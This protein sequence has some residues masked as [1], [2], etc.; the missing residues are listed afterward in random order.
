L[1]KHASSGITETAP[2]SRLP[3]VKNL[4]FPKCNITFVPQ[5]YHF[6]P[7]PM[8]KKSP[9]FQLHES[10]KYSKTSPDIWQVSR[11]V[12]FLGRRD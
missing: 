10:H 8:V 3:E 5:L 1:L 4:C 11:T 2:V 7:A 12:Y 6:G 9:E